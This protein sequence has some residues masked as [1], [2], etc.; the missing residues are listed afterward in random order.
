MGIGSAV[1]A[2][3]SGLAGDGSRAAQQA[4][5]GLVFGGIGFGLIA[6]A[7]R[8]RRRARDA[9][10]RR[11]EHPD[12]PWL[13]RRD[14]AEGRIESTTRSTLVRAWTFAG[15]W[16]LISAPLPI[17]VLREY[18]GGNRLALLGLLFPA[19][20][21]GLLVWAVRETLR[22]RKFGTSIL[23]LDTIPAAPGRELHGVV[24]VRSPGFVPYEGFHAKLACVHQVTTGTG[25]HRTTRERILWQEERTVTPRR[26][27]AARGHVQ[28]PVSFRLPREGH[29][30]DESD[31]D[32]LILWRLVIT[33]D[34]P[35]VDFSATF[36]LPVFRT[37]G[38]DTPLSTG[39][40]PNPPETEIEYEPPT[41]SRIRVTSNRRGTE[42]YFP[43]AR[44]PGVAASL[45]AFTV[46]WAGFGWL[47]VHLDAP[48]FFPTVVGLFGTLLAYGA[49]TLWLGTSRIRIDGR[50]VSLRRGILGLGRAR[51]FRA[52]E[53]TD[54]ELGI[55]MQAGGVPY[56]EIR[57]STEDDERGVRA[58]DGIRDKRHGRWLVRRMYEALG[59]RPAAAE[60]GTLSGSGQRG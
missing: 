45:T 24:R 56:Y 29:E 12:R 5:F 9:E 36:E 40:R 37:A 47:L 35:G 52:D 25:R 39:P 55:G 44:N 57:L 3:R 31:P 34:V 13:W 16:N 15:F 38:T 4:L 51:T 32:S 19:I 20:G 21:L 53:I 48:I 6:T 42:L 26:G 7:A 30:T 22:Y 1:L 50:N 46:L 11:R 49:A 8:G 2:V 17:L 59:R 43:T 27:G 23:E 60:D 10:T 18:G 58:A 54:I 28:I 14:W 33:A 41:D